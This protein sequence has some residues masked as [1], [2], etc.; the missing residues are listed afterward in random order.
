[1]PWANGNS[2]R[3]SV[4]RHLYIV[5]CHQCVHSSYGRPIATRSNIYLRVCR[6]SHL[7]YERRLLLSCIHHF[8]SDLINNM[9]HMRISGTEPSSVILSQKKVIQKVEK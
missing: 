4:P 6:E 7:L 8:K 5:F 9:D 2:L 3:Y 1:M